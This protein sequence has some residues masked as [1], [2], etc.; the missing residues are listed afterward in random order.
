MSKIKTG[1]KLSFCTAKIT[2]ITAIKSYT[3][4]SEVAV[5]GWS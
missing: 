2:A 1:V 4:T 3:I 5:D